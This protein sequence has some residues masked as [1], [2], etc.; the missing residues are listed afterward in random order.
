MYTKSLPFLGVDLAWRGK[1]ETG[2]VALDA[3][4]TIVDAGWER[5]TEEVARWINE[6]SG[7][8]ATV[9]VDAP[10]VVENPTGMRECEKEVGRRYGSWQVYA[11][12]SNTAR[13]MTAG[14]HLRE[15]LEA[16]GFRYDDGTGGNAT[17]GRRVLECYPYTTIVGVESLGYDRERPRYKRQ[18]RKLQAADW[19]PLRSRETD[20]LIRRVAALASEDPPMDLTSHPVTRTLVDEPTPESTV[21]AKHREDLLDAALCAW[22]AA[23]WVRFGTDR[24]QVLG[25]NDPPANGRRAT[26]VAPARASQR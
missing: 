1:N 21:A 5:G 7:D 20:E 10:L 17:R 15:L 24:C 19:K 14:V 25:R 4:G 18:P 22:T 6:R 3:R 12:A 13:G 8:R 2:L 11:N 9:F 26:I 16:R 23:L